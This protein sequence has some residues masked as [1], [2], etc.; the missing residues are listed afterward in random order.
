MEWAERIGRR[1]KL[2]DLHILL[3][4]SQH[5]SMVRAASHLAVS[6]PVISKVIAELEATIG[7]KL[8]ERNR[9]GVELTEAGHVLLRRGVVVFDELQQGVREI[10]S[11]A[12]PAAGELRI[13]GPGTVVGGLFPVVMERLS[14]SHPRM[15]FRVSQ[16]TDVAQQ[17]QELRERRV[18]LVIRR[19][20]D[21]IQN[22][23]DLA[24]EVLF[25]DP[26]LI[27]AGNNNPW[28]RRRNIKLA[29]LV[30][31]P[32]VLPPSDTDVGSYIKE[33]FGQTKL[34]VPSAR[35][36]AASMDLNHALLATG[37]YLAIYPHSLLM[38]S[39]KRLAIKKLMVE[40]PEKV[41][42]FGAIYL[43]RRQLSAAAKLFI[44]CAREVS[45]P[46]ARQFTNK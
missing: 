12:D 40:I 4:V 44:N 37:R 29:Q 42:E 6:Q 15:T 21:G 2:R 5:G 25:N 43:K 26:P 3:V 41:M 34:P 10:E 39:G 32:W 8:L 13:A 24:V 7:S 36:V 31:E 45:A 46:L 30:N 19:L 38:F 23:S 14:R 20:S 11:L 18:D 17:V 35:I 22:E 28:V 1:I 16:V 9:T 27:A 33:L